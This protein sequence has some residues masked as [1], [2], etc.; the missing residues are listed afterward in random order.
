MKIEAAA[1]QVLGAR[2]RQEDA[3]TVFPTGSMPELFGVFDGLG[4]H[5]YGD[6][7][8]RIAA[9]T[10]NDRGAEP[11][12][13]LDETLRLADERIRKTLRDA[14]TTATLLGIDAKTSTGFIAHAGDSRIYRIRNGQL[15]HLTFDHNETWESSRGSDMPKEAV[16]AMTTHFLVNCLGSANGPMRLRVDTLTFTVEAGDR[17]LLFTDGL[18]GELADEDILTLS[19]SGTPQ[20]VVDRLLEASTEADDNTTVICVEAR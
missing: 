10:V 12:E 16:N 15:E 4:G 17:F 19:S 14:G 13:R 2:E 7:A 3:Y 5:G 18:N 9:E 6:E 11:K 20:Q 1:G 8:S